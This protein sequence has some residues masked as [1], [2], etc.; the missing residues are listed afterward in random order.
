MNK[1]SKFP[2]DVICELHPLFKGLTWVACARSS[3]ETRVAI[4]HVFVEK[5]GTEWRL[6]ATDGRRMHIHE[7]DA[8]LFD[9]DIDGLEPGLYEVVA[10]SSKFIVVAKSEEL[11]LKA[12]PNWRQ[13]V[14]DFT[15]TR[16]DTFDARTLSKIGIRTGVLLASDFA[17]DAIGFGSGYKKDDSVCVTYGSAGNGSPFVITH[18]L[19]KAIV[20]PMKLDDDDKADPTAEKPETEADATPEFASIAK[21]IAAALKNGE[22]VTLATDADGTMKVKKNRVRKTK[23]KAEA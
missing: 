10:K 23:E 16:T 15:P 18:E 14:P 12:Y 11:E 4:C 2:A 8:G 9:T 19:G 20:M 21:E 22:S 3:D 6:V 1:F 17:A 13:V 5:N 7:F